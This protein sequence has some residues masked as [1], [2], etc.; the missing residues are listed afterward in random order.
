MQ[1]QL[2]TFLEIWGLREQ[3]LFLK[4]CQSLID[5]YQEIG[6]LDETENI[7]EETTKTIL[8]RTAYLLSLISEA[9][10]S[11]MVQASSKC[12]QLWKKMEKVNAGI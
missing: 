5:L 11:R 1:K 7:D 9:H 8:L 12:P 2:N 4:D 3:K 10:G 6:S